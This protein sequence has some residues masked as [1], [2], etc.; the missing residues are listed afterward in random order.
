MKGTET[1]KKLKYVFFTGATGGLGE[2]CVKALSATGGWV[3][4]AA[5][6][7]A[8]KLESLGQLPNVVPLRCDVTSQQSVESALEAVRAHTAAL[9]AVVNFAGVVSFASMVEGDCLREIE[10]LLAVNVLGTA[11]VNRVFFES[12]LAGHGRIVNC[13]SESGW[14]TPQPFSGPYALSKYALEAYND[15]LRRELMYLGIPVV[16]IQPGSYKTQ[17]TRQVYEGFDKAEACTKYYGKVL[18]RMKPLMV[19]ELGH[20]SDPRLLVRVVLKAL[21]ARRP[22]IRYRAGTGK[23]L[24]LL[25][26]LPDSM[27][28]KVYKWI[29]KQNVFFKAAKKNGR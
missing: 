28:D 2:M 18:S 13:S 8:A 16:K 3:V 24:S 5:G 20:D 23:L 10:K 26:I 11:R 6:M 4:F 7:N 15:S 1:F 14:M 27:L 25:E 12:I 17:M 29:M 21:S 19:M 22:R 9:D